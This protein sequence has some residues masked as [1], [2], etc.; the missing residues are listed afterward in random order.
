MPDT[1]VSAHDYED[2]D[3][4][5]THD[6][7]VKSPTVDAP[8][9]RPQARAIFGPYALL[10][11]L[12][13]GPLGKRWLARHRFELTAHV[14]HRL[15][16]CDGPDDVRR[17]RKAVGT[18]QTLS[19]PH[20]MTPEFAGVRRGGE[21]WVASRYTGDRDG[22]VS[23]RRLVAMKGGALG[24]QEARHATEQLLQA[25]EY[26]HARGVIHGPVNEEEILINRRGSVAIELYGLTRL[27]GDDQNACHQALV[28]EEVRSIAMLAAGMLLGQDVDDA[29]LDRRL[30]ATVDVGSLATWLR[31][32]LQPGAGFLT[33]EEAASALPWRR[34]GGADDQSAPLVTTRRLKSIFS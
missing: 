26:A 31:T 30:E 11:P 33:A 20:L 3:Q 7:P 24:H 4:R 1:L 28:R 34:G 19:S 22:P 16:L 8:W 13:P 25:V 2:L 17:F 6:S 10:R 12:H 5:F 23:L 14:I 29:N 21:A 27:L 15:H 18:L 9:P 32:A